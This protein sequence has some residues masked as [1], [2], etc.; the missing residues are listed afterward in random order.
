MTAFTI[1]EAMATVATKSGSDESVLVFTSRG[2]LDSIRVP[3]FLLHPNRTLVHA[4][5][6]GLRM[7]VRSDCLYRYKGAVACVDG[8]SQQAL[9]RD[10]RRMCTEGNTR[11]ITPLRTAGGAPL[12][13]T[14]TS[15][16]QCH[17]PAERH[18]TDLLLM[19]VTD[20]LITSP[21]PHEIAMAFDLTPA[22]ARIAGA[23]G[24]GKTPQECAVMLDVKVSTIRTHLVS[25]YRKTATG[26]Q[27]HLA[28]LIQALSLF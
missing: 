10:M 24:S 3:L 28:R 2:L 27:V 20:R 6:A 23:I 16:W 12:P 13:A 9:D 18:R 15:L 5:P 25:I 19:A 14:V 4:N 22:E 8:E 17:I 7:F 1:P 21:E 11:S 26:S